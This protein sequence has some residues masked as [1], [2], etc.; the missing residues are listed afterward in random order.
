MLPD[1]PNR[2]AGPTP[3][4][5]PEPAFRLNPTTI[6]PN[7]P[8]IPPPP[9]RRLPVLPLAI[10]LVALLA[11]GALFM[12]GY[13]MGRQMALE[14][15][16]PATA[17][18]AFEPFWDT[19]RT[20]T[21]RYAGGDVDEDALIQGAIRGMIESLGDPYSSY[22]TSDEYHQSLQGISGQFEGIG[23]EMA[24]EAPDGT[25]GCSTLGPDCT[26]VVVAPLEGS[27]AEK[28]G[29]RPGD[30]VIAADGAG[31]DGLTVDGALHP[32]EQSQSLPRHTARWMDRGGS[33][34]DDP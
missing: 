14:P 26:L 24:T 12:S 25:Q 7:A 23:A 17:S 34:E 8:F 9:K 15:G 28:A 21:Q 29:L 1:D 11:G 5:D 22:L 13:T 2:P 3:P 4:S 16:T 33:T 6:T 32:G 10:A 27:P 31:F 30:F 20:I 18:D 19:Y